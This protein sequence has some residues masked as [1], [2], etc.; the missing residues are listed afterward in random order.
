MKKRKSVIAFIVMIALFC[1]TV[2]GCGGKTS[3]YEERIAQLESENQTLRDQ[4]DALNAQLNIGSGLY[5]SDWS[6][7]GEAWEGSGGANISFSAKP[8]SYQEGMTAELMVYLDGNAVADAKC[9]WDGSA[10]TAWA[11][12]P[13]GDGYGYFCLLTDAQGNSSQVLLSSPDNPVEYSLVY[14]QTS[15]TAYCNVYLEDWTSDNSSLTISSGFA[16]VQLPQLPE[17]GVENADFRGAQLVL[18][19]NGQ[20][21][22][23]KNLDMPKG[24]GAGSYEAALENIRFDLPELSEDDQLD[25]MLLATLTSDAVI[26]TNAGSWFLSE[27]V[28]NLVVG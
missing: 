16:M 12:V 22:D 25:L 20:E 4:I 8:A 18:M 10:F 21:I 7:T 9:S 11:S 14:L 2:T 15:L 23:S 3:E 19:L 24:E 13:A 17:P 5:L 6:L 1:V 26:S 28:L 27:G